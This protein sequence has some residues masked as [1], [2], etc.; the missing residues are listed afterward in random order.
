MLPWA[1]SKAPC[2]DPVTKTADFLFEQ[3][4]HKNTFLDKMKMLP[5]LA[6]ILK[7]TFFLSMF[8]PRMEKVLTTNWTKT[9]YANFDFF[10]QKS[11]YLVLGDHDLLVFFLKKIIYKQQCIL[12]RLNYLLH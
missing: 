6:R 7:N 4:R 1:P 5:I 11:T 9:L 12:R 10:R 3:C 8:L 2:T